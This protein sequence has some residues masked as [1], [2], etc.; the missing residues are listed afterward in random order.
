MVKS[1]VKKEEIIANIIFFAIAFVVSII[2]LYIFDIHWNFY[3][4]GNLFPPEKYVFNDRKIYLY[5]GIIGA[6][7][8]FAIIK[9]LLLGIKEEENV[10]N[11]KKK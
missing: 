1:L 7:L 3:P 6:I 2:I 11:S 5:G 4:N 9:V 8:I 10:W